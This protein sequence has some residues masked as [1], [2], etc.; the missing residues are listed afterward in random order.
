MELTIIIDGVVPVRRIR[1]QRAAPEIAKPFEGRPQELSRIL[2]DSRPTHVRNQLVDFVCAK[3]A[4]FQSANHGIAISILQLAPFRLN[5]RQ[6]PSR[7]GCFGQ[8]QVAARTVL[9]TNFP[10]VDCGQTCEKWLAIELRVAD[11]PRSNDARVNCQ[12]HQRMA[13]VAA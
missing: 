12:H 8:W 5:D 11:I 3:S 7:I 4:R 10:F 6:Q 13:Q 1:V 2:A 9:K